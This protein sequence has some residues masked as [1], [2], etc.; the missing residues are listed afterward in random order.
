MSAVTF[1][2]LATGLDTASIVA[3]LVELKR[4]PV[5]RLESRR[6]DFQGQLAALDTLKTK[7]LAL[8]D[9][10]AGLDTLGEFNALG[11]S[12]SHENILTATAGSDAAPGVY[13]IV[14]QSLAT[15]RREVSQGYDTAEAVV[16]GGTIW[17]NIG[18]GATPLVVP[19]GTTLAELRDLVN[20]S[21]PGVSA[22]IVN[23]GSPT[24][25]HH[26]VL[27]SDQAG[28]EGE[29]TVN[30]AGLTGGQPPAMTVT[31][32]AADAQLTVDGISVTASGNQLSGVISGL[33][34]DLHQAEPGT[35]INL[36]VAVDGTAVESAVEN[37][38]NSYNDLFA[39][40]QAQAQPDGDLRGNPT[41]R[42]VAN[43]MENIFTSQ[44]AT[45][46]GGVSMLWQVGIRTGEDRQ[47]IWNPEQFREAMAEDFQAVRNLFIENDGSLGKAYLIRTAIDDMTHS[48]DGLF[49]ISKDALDSKIST[50]D[51]T[52][53]R[54]E[55]GI[56]SYRL[57]LE[58]RFTAMERMVAQLQ[59]QGNYLTSIGF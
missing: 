42:A 49:R 59:A 57:N 53:E 2:G 24:G 20:G 18:G 45:G 23:D 31:R 9:A 16:G 25:G 21:V 10:A 34:L 46:D 5:Y 38:V 58:A 36:T 7:L 11:A 50:A 54:Y 6:E 8:Q 27:R 22:S 52:I 26:L 55:R 37:L 17:F 28:L 12:S 40:I 14:V 1:T 39:F 48:V 44:L 56:E 13:E 47:M 30:L 32:T 33:T 4:G 51:R 15:V 3:Q 35:V 41:L 29:F 19:D 43:R